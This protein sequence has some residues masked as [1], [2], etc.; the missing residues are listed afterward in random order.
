MNEKHLLTT[1]EIYP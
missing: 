1:T